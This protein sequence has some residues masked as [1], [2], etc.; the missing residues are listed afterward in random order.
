MR[1]GLNEGDREC[2]CIKDEREILIQE[3]LNGDVKE[4]RKS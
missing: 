2:A 4:Y 1:V 3:G